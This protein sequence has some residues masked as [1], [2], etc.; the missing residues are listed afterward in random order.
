MRKDMTCVCNL[1]RALHKGLLSALYGIAFLSAYIKKMHLWDHTNG[2]VLSPMT[3]FL[4]SAIIDRHLLEGGWGRGARDS[5]E[6]IM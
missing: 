5:Y 4:H 6:K 2:R 3:V 1:Y